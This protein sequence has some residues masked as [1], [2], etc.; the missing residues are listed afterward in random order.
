[1]RKW[2]DVKNPKIH[3]PLL[4][5]YIPGGH[6][7]TCPSMLWIRKPLGLDTVKRLL[8]FPCFSAK[9]GDWV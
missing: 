9:A 8:R 1:M 7:E 3:H 4:L 2:S 6:L 5:K